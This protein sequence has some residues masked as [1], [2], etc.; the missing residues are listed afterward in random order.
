MINETGYKNY[1]TL[2]Y[3]FKNKILV[4]FKDLDNIFYNGLIL[5]L[6]E[7]KLTL[8]L[9][10]RVKG[11]IPFLLEDINPDSINKFREVGE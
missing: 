1:R 3:Y 5:E 2:L 11:E 7:Q 10:E 8:V 9:R 6:N 4:H